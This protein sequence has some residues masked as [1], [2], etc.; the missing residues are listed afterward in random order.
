MM[1]D[2]NNPYRQSFEEPVR[3][4]RPKSNPLAIVGFVLAFCLPPIG[5]LLSF[6]ALFRAPRAFAVAGIIVGIIGS[7]ILGVFGVWAIPLGLRV[8]EVVVDGTKVKEAA[9]AYVGTNSAPPPD[10][11]SLHLPTEFTVDPWGQAYRFTPGDAGSWTL[12]SAGMD[13]AWDTADD[14]MLDDTM[15]EQEMGNAVGD[16]VGAHYEEKWGGKKP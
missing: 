16:A 8:S 15:D 7:A 1:D 5:L 14:F 13:G 10:L 6:I 4:E 9:A 3:A 11:S 12:A 2:S